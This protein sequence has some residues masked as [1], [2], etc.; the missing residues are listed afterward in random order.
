MNY[1][2]LKTYLMKTTIK[3]LIVVFLLVVSSFGQAQNVT[4]H[5]RGTFINFAYQDER[6]KYINPV[7]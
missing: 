3:I 2:P 5:V 6:N 7:Y 4:K 1:Q